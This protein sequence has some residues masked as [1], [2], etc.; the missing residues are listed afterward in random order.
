MCTSP[1]VTAHG[2]GPGM[3]A[4]TSAAAAPGSPGMEIDGVLMEDVSGTAAEAC[5]PPDQSLTSALD[6]SVLLR[7]RF[8]E[9]LHHLL[10]FNCVFQAAS[11]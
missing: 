2:W 6:R 10:V 9:E 11:H 4:V 1:S 5:C 3:W 7:P 8:S